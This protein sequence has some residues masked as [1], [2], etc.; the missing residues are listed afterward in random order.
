MSNHKDALLKVWEREILVQEYPLGGYRACQLAGVNRDAGS[1]QQHAYRLGL[2]IRNP[3]STWLT[4][5]AKDLIRYWYPLGGIPAIR[6]HTTLLDIY[7]LDNIRKWA[8]RNKIY[9]NKD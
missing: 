2:H 1:I 6:E 9:R 5:E 7:P 3:T 8:N 4:K